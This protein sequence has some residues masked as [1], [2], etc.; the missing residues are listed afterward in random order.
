[1][2]AM[3]T[4]RPKN[5]SPSPGPQPASPCV[6]MTTAIAPK[7][8]SDAHIAPRAT[9]RPRR[10]RK[11]ASASGADVAPG[12]AAGLRLTTSPPWPE[13]A[14]SQAA[15]RDVGDEDRPGAQVVELVHEPVAADPRDHG[16]H[17]DPRLVLH[18]RHGRR[19]Q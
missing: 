11:G 4:P 18:R 6:D 19:L 13:V 9:A 14:A 2:K 15:G 12:P 8:T 7:T 17:G 10:E 3:T 1:M 16:P 5:I